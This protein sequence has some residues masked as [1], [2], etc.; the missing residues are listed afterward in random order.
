[1][2][3]YYSVYPISIC[4]SHKVDLFCFNWIVVLFRWDFYKSGRY[5]K[6]VCTW[7]NIF[8]RVGICFA[9]VNLLD[10]CPVN[11]EKLNW[12][13]K[14]EEKVIYFPVR[15]DLLHFVCDAWK[16]KCVFVLLRLQKAAFNHFSGFWNHFL[17][18]LSDFTPYKFRSLGE[19]KYKIW[20]KLSIY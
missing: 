7:V 9:M 16:I 19:L 13:G 1:M 4:C 12:K 8:P 10:N 3:R 14:S 17:F 15:F 11:A 18:I 20:K 6:S 2:V 5:L